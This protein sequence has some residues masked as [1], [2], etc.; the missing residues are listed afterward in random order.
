MY[1]FSIF[2]FVI[3]THVLFFLITKLYENIIMFHDE[4][5]SKKHWNVFM[6]HLNIYSNTF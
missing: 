3:T 5:L 4:Q 1:L 2:F 6:M